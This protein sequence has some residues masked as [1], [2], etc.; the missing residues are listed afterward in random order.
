MS[1]TLSVSP[2]K[3]IL[4]QAT[5]NKDNVIKKSNMYYYKKNIIIL[6][7]HKIYMLNF[8]L[9]NFYTYKYYCKFLKLCEY[10]NSAI[11]LFYIKLR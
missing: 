9:A 10:L 1:Q 8:T 7:K 3:Y 5:E 4:K 2:G 11:L 6:V